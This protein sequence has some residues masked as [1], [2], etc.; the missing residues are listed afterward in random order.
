MDA[1]VARTASAVIAFTVPAVPTGMKTGVSMVNLS[2][3][4]SDV[5]VAAKLR[6]GRAT[7]LDSIARVVTY[8][9]DKGLEVAVG[10]E[11]SSRADV[12]FLIEAV[13]AAEALAAAF[14]VLNLLQDCKLDY[15]ALRRVYL[16]A[17]WMAA[18]GIAP[19]PSSLMVMPHGV[20]LVEQTRRTKHRCPSG[21]R[22]ARPR[23]APAWAG[24]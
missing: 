7:A 6:G 5:Q 15:L 22:R 12:E 21:C 19:V 2:V 8:A 10:G 9:R 24:G 23:S 1:P 16:P 4:V 17:E 3:P 18:A 11:D 13:A 14:H 20:C